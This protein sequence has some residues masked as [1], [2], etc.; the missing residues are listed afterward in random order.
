MDA[1]TIDITVITVGHP[2]GRL[3]RNQDAATSK[4][5]TPSVGDYA[6]KCKSWTS[7]R[8][9]RKFISLSLENK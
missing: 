2:K 3:T 5:Y 1:S 9:Q 7:R 8:I 4:Q 6:S